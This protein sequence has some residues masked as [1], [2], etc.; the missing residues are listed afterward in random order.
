MRRR[1]LGYALDD[2]LE[3]ALPISTVRCDPQKGVAHPQEQATLAPL[4]VQ[5]TPN[6]ATIPTIPI[7]YHNKQKKVL[8]VEHFYIE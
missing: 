1:S 2:P 8:H 5:C 3:E 7:G 4:K 6:Y